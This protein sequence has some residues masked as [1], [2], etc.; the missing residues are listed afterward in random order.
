MDMDN[1]VGVQG[2]AWVGAAAS[3]TRTQ[4]EALPAEEREKYE[5]LAKE[6]GRLARKEKQHAIANAEELL[7]P[8]EA[9]R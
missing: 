2:R 4:F 6:E 1:Q 9:Q 7:N 3:Y 5:A 8:S